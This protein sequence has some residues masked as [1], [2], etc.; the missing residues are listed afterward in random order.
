M[1][2]FRLCGNAATLAFKRAKNKVN[3]MAQSRIHG[4]PNS[5]RLLALRMAVGFSTLALVGAASAFLAPSPANAKPQFAAQTGLA[6][7][8]CHVNPAGGGKL[9]SF[10]QKFKANGFKLKK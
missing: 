7:G 10:G 9:K 6:C 3:P 5:I 1:S 8:R 4:M 2:I